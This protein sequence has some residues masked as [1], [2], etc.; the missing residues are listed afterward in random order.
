[1]L[2]F[3]FPLDFKYRTSANSSE[4][5]GQPIITKIPSVKNSQLSVAFHT[6][7]AM[8]I[9]GKR[10]LVIEL[11]TYAKVGPLRMNEIFYHG[12]DGDGYEPFWLQL[13]SIQINDR[14]LINHIVSP[15]VN[16]TDIKVLQT[17]VNLCITLLP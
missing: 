17:F 2:S 6:Q 14:L 9:V 12:R 13:L 10:D 15:L 11:E 7:N 16:P 4:V 8:K 3:Q 1:M 5:L